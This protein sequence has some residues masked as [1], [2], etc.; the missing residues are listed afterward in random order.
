M[1]GHHGPLV[2][3]SCIHDIKV[4]IFLLKKCGESC[5]DFGSKKW[6]GY[7]YNTTRHEIIAL[8]ALKHVAWNKS[9]R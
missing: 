9:V 8:S 3:S 7:A 5:S 4:L 1:Q 2:K 6:H